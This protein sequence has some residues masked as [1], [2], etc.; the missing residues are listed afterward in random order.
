MS[1]PHGNLPRN[2]GTVGDQPPFA[3]STCGFGGFLTL[4]H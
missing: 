1:E 4:A 2:R 3:A